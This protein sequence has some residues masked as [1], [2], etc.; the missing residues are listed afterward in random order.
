[1]QGIAGGALYLREPK[2]VLPSLWTSRLDP[3]RAPHSATSLIQGFRHWDRQFCGWCEVRSASPH[4]WS[5]AAPSLGFRVHSI[6]TQNSRMVS[7]LKAVGST[8]KH[9]GQGSRPGYRSVSFNVSIVFR[10]V[11]SMSSWTRSAY[12]DQ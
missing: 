7:V 3:V 1:S 5:V 10:D 9:L 4:L 6:R 11:P 2:A 8:A 12:W